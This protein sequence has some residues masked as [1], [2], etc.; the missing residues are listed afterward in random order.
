MSTNKGGSTPSLIDRLT[1]GIDR[2]TAGLFLWPADASSPGGDEEA[3]RAVC[4]RRFDRHA[5]IVAVTVMVFAVL[6]WPSDLVTLRRLPEDRPVFVEW[7]LYAA[8]FSLLYIAVPRRLVGRH[9]FWLFAATTGVAFFLTG[10]AFASLGGLELPYVHFC[11]V[12]PFV[13]IAL[14]VRLATR[15][16]ITAFLGAATLAGV[17]LPFPVHRG[18]PFVPMT[19]TQMSGMIGLSMMFGHTLLILLKQNFLQAQELARRSAA[20]ARHGE[21]LEERVAEKTRELRRLLSYVE[22]AQESERTRIARE[23]HDA[24]GQELLALRYSL[25]YTRTRYADDPAAIGP[26]LDDVGDLLART[27]GSVREIIALLRPRILDDLG[28]VAAAK[29]LV[30]SVAARSGFACELRVSGGDAE[31]VDP[32]SGTAAFRILQEALTNVVKH[33]GARRVE[34]SVDILPERLDLRIA[35]DGIGIEKAAAETVDAQPGDGAPER[36]FGL[37]GMRERAGA[38]GG[39]LSVTARPEGGTLVHC[40]LPLRPDEAA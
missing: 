15:A 24:L 35:D 19:C 17:F 34:V 25:S 20:L 16:G 26:N 31:R 18:S 5:H 40:L 1:A 29:W 22:T 11:Y 7:R 37:L 39:T 28:F 2:L 8:G 23:L 12:I 4:V 13:T 38:L 21:L 30:G 6:F 14:P 9:L 36:G 32:G 3:F 27:A 10:R 33:A